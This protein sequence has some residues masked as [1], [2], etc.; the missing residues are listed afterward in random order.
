MAKKI[1]TPFDRMVM[2]VKNAG[3][4][5]LEE[6]YSDDGAHGFM[7][8]DEN[9][10]FYVGEPT[11]KEWYWK[12][13]GKIAVDNNN[14]FNKWSQVPFFVW[15]PETDDEVKRILDAIR[16]I[17]TNEGESLSDEFE[18]CHEMFGFE[19]PDSPSE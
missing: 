9:V 16:F 11:G 15:L 7:Y 17:S 6:V 1:I 3:Y 2:A 4:T 18:E 14:S 10:I 19:R 12:L 8:R 5:P 13:D